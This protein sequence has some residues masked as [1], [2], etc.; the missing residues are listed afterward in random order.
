[1]SDRWRSE[2]AAGPEPVRVRAGDSRRPAY[3]K[4]THYLQAGRQGEESSG[5]GGVVVLG[6]L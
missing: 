2:L 6:W 5:P 4:L 1:M 3:F